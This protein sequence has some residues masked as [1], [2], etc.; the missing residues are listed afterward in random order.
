VYLRVMKEDKTTY[1]IINQSCLDAFNH[2]NKGIDLTFLDPP[3]NQQKKYAYHD[4][5]M[6]EA[7]YWQFMKDVCT[8]TFELTNEGGAIYFMQ[9]EKN[10]EFVLTILR[11][12]GWTLQ[13]IIIW[14]KKTSAVPVA[15]KYGKQYQIIAY[16]TKGKR[17]KTFHRLRI[18]PELPANYKH[19]RE[20]GIYV[21][22]V[23]NDIRELTSG[24]FAGKEAVRNEGGGRFHKQQ[25]PLALL[26]RIIL[27]SSNVGDMVFDPFAGTGTTSLVAHQLQRNSIAVEIDPKNAD[28]ID[29]RLSEIRN[30]DL[31]GKYHKDYI[32]TKDLSEIWGENMD[33]I[34][35]PER[36]NNL[37]TKL[38]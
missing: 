28:Y 27:S 2:I 37:Q 22:D 38:F 16:A 10:A 8:K 6:D 35:I 9:R 25:S 3:F 20:N 14:K 17:A 13:N 32:C 29:K 4:D 19:K 5:N 1:E 12:S 23:W 21:T 7:T 30:A 31:I 34:F 24:F 15:T 18:D 26:L 11:E 33:E 36:D